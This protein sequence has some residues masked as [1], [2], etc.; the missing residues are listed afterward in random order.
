MIS[1][2]RDRTLLFDLDVAIQR[3]N[4]ACPTTRRRWLSPA[5]I[6]T[7]FG[8]GLRCRSIRGATLTPQLKTK[9]SVA[10]KTSEIVVW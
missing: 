6:T 3:L 4:Q 5:C 1:D 8:N 2:D 10:W 9:I 7:C